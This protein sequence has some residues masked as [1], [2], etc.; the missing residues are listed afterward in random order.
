MIRQEM[1]PWF[2]EL[3]PLVS[4]SF[5]LDTTDAKGLYLWLEKAT[6]PT[7]GTS[8]PFMSIANRRRIWCV[9]EEIKKLYVERVNESLESEDEDDEAAMEIMEESSSLHM[10]IVMY[11]QPKGGITT[12]Q[13]WIRSW[14]ELKHPS[15]VFESFWAPTGTLAGLGVKFGTDRRIFGQGENKE[16]GIS[17]R[18]V[19]IPADEW[20]KQIVLHLD[21]INIL[22]QAAANTSI[23]ALSV[24]LS[25]V[26]PIRL[27]IANYMC[28]LY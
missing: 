2:W 22:E 4:P 21:E 19:F 26:V 28:R 27:F 24:S 25:F 7:F 12:S 23:K 14:D 17:N 1:L 8:G 18:S 16:D 9:C 10:P 6:R 20:I 15:K 13:Q 3:E 11:P 5:V